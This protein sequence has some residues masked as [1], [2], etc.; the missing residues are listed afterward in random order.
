MLEFMQNLNG[1]S[2]FKNVEHQPNRCII[3]S[4]LI[5]YPLNLHKKSHFIHRLHKNQTAAAM[6][7]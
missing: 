6:Y 2:A 4:L 1:L 3:H 5:A 7:L